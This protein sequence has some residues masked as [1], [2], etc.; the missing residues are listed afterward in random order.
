M[1]SPKTKGLSSKQGGDIAVLEKNHT[2]NTNPGSQYMH[3]EGSWEKMPLPNP[4]KVW[5]RRDL[6]VHLIPPP[7]TFQ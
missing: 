3:S 4:K 6:E 7:S 5:V 2:S 1:S